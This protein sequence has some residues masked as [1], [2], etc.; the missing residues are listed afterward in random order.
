MVLVSDFFEGGDPGRLLY[1]VRKLVEQGSTV[2]GL[3]ALD[4]EA[5]PVYDREL[6]AR[7]VGLGA[8]VGAMTP[9]ALAA[10][11]AEKVGR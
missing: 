6:A 8:H 3:A 10:F 7:M 4:E 2:L 5:D 11:V 1:G 9:G